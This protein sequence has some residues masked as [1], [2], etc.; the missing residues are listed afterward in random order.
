MLTG[1]VICVRT[2]LTKSPEE[3]IIM[4]SKIFA[5]GKADLGAST[6][7]NFLAL[8]EKARPAGFGML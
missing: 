6:I 2:E 5:E 8:G 3:V 4:M 1:S 7:K